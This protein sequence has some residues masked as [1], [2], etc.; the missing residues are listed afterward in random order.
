MSKR[1]SSLGR[2][3]DSLLGD[4]KIENVSP[5]GASSISEVLLDDIEPNKHQPRSFFDKEG[6]DELASSI[7]SVGI[8]QPITLCVNTEGIKKYKIISGE[9]RYRAAL[10]AGLTTIP[11][12]IRT[13]EDEQI[14]EMALIENIQREDL[15][16]I[17][18]ALAFQKLLDQYGLTQEELSSKVGKNRATISNYIRLLKLPSQVQIA[19]K[20]DKLT[21][22]HARALLSI[23]NS[24]TQLEIFKRIV[25]EGL[26]VRD[27]E[28]IVRSLKA[29]DNTKNDKDLS[30]TPDSRAEEFDILAKQFS[31]IFRTKVNFSMNK[32]GKGKITIS[33]TDEEQLE[34]IL[35]L[36]DSL[37]NP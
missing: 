7:K 27:V 12:Y 32:K 17:E 11:A 16:P 23:D 25:K 37:N 8:V 35:H 22:G 18:I 5:S 3:L 19:L 21:M 34:N 33:F 2:G 31:N 24:N 30:K 6:L 26:S 13:V 36:L 10:K 29:S 28:E 20:E 15:N 4:I 14:M 1:K 9:R